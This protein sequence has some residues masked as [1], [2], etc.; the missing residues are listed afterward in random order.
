MRVELPV[1]SAAEVEVDV[2]PQRLLLRVPGRLRL[3]LPLPLEVRTCH[4]C[5][6]IEFAAATFSNPNPVPL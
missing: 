6:R 4:A 1:E 5:R 3:D 2:Q